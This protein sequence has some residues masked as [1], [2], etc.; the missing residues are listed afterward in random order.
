MYWYDGSLRSD[1][2]DGIDKSS[3]VEGPFNSLGLRFGASVFTT[4]RVYDHSLN[5]VRSQYAAHCDRLSLSLQEFGWDLPD[6]SAVTEGCVQLQSSYPVLRITLFS[7]GSEWITGRPLPAGLP[8]KQNAGVSCWL[9]PSTYARSLPAHKTGNY[10]A[11][12]LARQQA[13]KHGADEAILTDVRGDWLETA[14]GNLWGWANGKWWSPAGNLPSSRC[15]PGLMRDRITK[16]LAEDGQSVTDR[17]W[18]SA[19]CANFEAIAYSNCVIELMPIHTILNGQTKLKYN[20]QHPSLVALI[21][22]LRSQN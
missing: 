5:D 22:K 2:G 8:S 16:I 7:D 17:D 12:H 9:S 10:L 13:Q 3:S 19:V 20:P 15:L 1:S 18:D 14:T 11:C 4:M 21:H 6:W